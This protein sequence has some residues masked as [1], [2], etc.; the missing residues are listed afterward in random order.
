[1]PIGGIEVNVL[2]RIAKASVWI[3]IAGVSIC[4]SVAEVKRV[5]HVEAT[6]LIPLL[7]F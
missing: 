7:V 3:R 4:I 6:V 5:D 1:V 2:I